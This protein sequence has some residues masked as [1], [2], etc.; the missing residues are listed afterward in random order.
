MLQTVKITVECPDFFFCADGTSCT[1]VPSAG[2][3][4][5]P[6]GEFGTAAADCNAHVDGHCSAFEVLLLSQVK[7]QVE[8]TF[9]DYKLKS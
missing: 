4:L 3:A 7:K 1:A 2:K 8:I 6:C 5:A 9:H